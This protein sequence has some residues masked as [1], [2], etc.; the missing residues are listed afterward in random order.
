M[1][2]YR[3][4]LPENC[5]PHVANAILENTVYRLVRGN[6]P[7]L[8]DFLSLRANNPSKP[9]TKEEECFANGLSVW[10]TREGAEKTKKVPQQNLCK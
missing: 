4:P 1:T 3:D 6:P 9:I 10:A 2:M 5:P 7:T 8:D